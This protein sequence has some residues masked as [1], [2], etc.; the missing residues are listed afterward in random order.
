MIPVGQA[1]LDLIVEH[2]RGFGTPLENCRHA[3]GQTGLCSGEFP[4]LSINYAC[5]GHF[6]DLRS[7]LDVPPA[8]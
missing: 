6:R 5:F 2:V 3:P 7:G 4:A 1:L 8:D